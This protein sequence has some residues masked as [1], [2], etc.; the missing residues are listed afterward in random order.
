M[1]TIRY[2]VDRQA[3][4][5]P[6]KVFMFA[7]E[8][9]LELT[10]SKLQEECT[11]LG[12]HL[13]RLGLNKGD[14]VSFMMGNGY[15]TTILFLGTM[16]SG[17]VI[18]PLN[19][20][21][22]PSQLTHVLT[23]SDTKVV[24]V[25]D[26]QLER[27]KESL[28]C[29][30]REIAIEVIDKNLGT[31]FPPCEVSQYELPDVAESDPALLLYTSGT[32]G[33]PKGAV[34]TNKSMV[35]GGQNV[36][37]AH[38]L[39][40]EDRGLVSL[41]LYHINAEIVSAMAPL[42]SGSSVV[43]P[44]RFSTAEFWPLMSEY[45]CTWFSVVPTIISYLASGSE[46]A[47]KGYQLDQVRFGRSASSALPPSLHKEFEEKF[48]ISIVE[49]M[50]L[51]ECA[52]PVF[53]NPLDPSRRKYGSPGQPVGNEAKVVDKHGQE[54]QR[55]VIGEILI[56]GDNVM[57]EYYKAP[58]VT[59][60]SL[61]PNG[62]F[63]TGDQGYMDEDGFV[64]VTGRIKELIIKGGENISPREI[65]EVLYC[66]PAILDAAACGIPDKHYGEEIMVCYM[67]KPGCDASADELREH[68]LQ[69]LGKFKTP[70]VLVCLE[71]LPRGPSG[72]IQ[73]LKLCDCVADKGID[74]NSPE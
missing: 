29:V 12:K 24:F 30:D 52:A 65:D 57:L 47:G 39:T 31:I 53:S 10:F 73:R 70:K 54:C 1:R 51:T 26:F 17:F 14:K 68:C 49:T 46:I 18:S 71:D 19:L 22:Q 34:L 25:T 60:K 16:Y 66:H 56:R 23:H 58:D 38:E 40:T 20:Q 59:A 55:G 48:G 2:H 3:A 45:R 21:A 72:K 36:C 64:F 62:W 13:K 63:H 41:P 33:L 44:E 6:D 27:L 42:V 50:G 7:P 35:A 69:H 74:V 67:L 11:K 8:P 4:E 37:L 28:A 43:M 61:E 15:Q 32:T 9:R 5:Q